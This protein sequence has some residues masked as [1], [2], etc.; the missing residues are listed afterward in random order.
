MFRPESWT[1]THGESH[2][3]GP[4]DRNLLISLIRDR[5]DAEREAEKQRLVLAERSIF[6]LSDAAVSDDFMAWS[7]FAPAS[8]VSSEEL[9]VSG[10]YG[11]YTH[12]LRGYNEA[13]DIRF[14]EWNT[15]IKQLNRYV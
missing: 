14:N 3:L 12:D 15:Q 13:C 9:P 2:V 8:L 4:D 6:G 10:I 7:R 5:K 1:P 11:T